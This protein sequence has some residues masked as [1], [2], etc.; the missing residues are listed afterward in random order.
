MSQP[1]AYPSSLYHEQNKQWCFL[2][3]TDHEICSWNNF[4][5]H[6]QNHKKQSCVHF[7]HCS[8]NCKKCEEGW[9][10]ELD[11]NNSRI[12]ADF[13]GA[14]ASPSLSKY[15]IYSHNK[16]AGCLSNGF[17]KIIATKIETGHLSSWPA[18]F[19]KIYVARSIWRL[20]WC[21]ILVVVQE[22]K[23]PSKFTQ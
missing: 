5:V 14:R 17:F 15:V 3:I 4:S 18:I 13:L 7:I 23:H 8:H 22:L 21:P 10:F 20:N 11:I 6:F 12:P 16:G 9:D 2:Q 1:T 19:Q